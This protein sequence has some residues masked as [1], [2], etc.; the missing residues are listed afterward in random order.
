MKDELWLFTMQ[1]PFGNGEAFLEN[2]LP[3]LAEGFQRV[4]LFPM[5]GEGTARPLPPGVQVEKSFSTPEAYRPMAWWRVLGR[6][7]PLLGL[8]RQARS[9]APSP[10]VYRKHRREFLSQLRQALERERLF[11]DRFAK[12][13]RPEQVRLYSYWTGDWATVLGLWKRRDPQVRFVSRM[14]GF[15]MFDHRAP[16]G[17]QRFQRFHLEQVERVYVIAQA[18]MEHVQRRFPEHAHKLRLSY[19]ATTDHGQAP[20]QPA[21]EL[22][23]ASCANLVELKRVHLIA[24]ALRHV[25]GP[26]QWTHF[27]D[28]PERGRVEAAVAQLP[29]TVR[30]ELK[31]SRPNREVIA[32]YQANPVDVFV[33]ASRTEGGAPVALQEAASFGI[34]L[35]AADA[36]G[37]A[38]V[39]TPESGILLPNG[40]TAQQL[41]R[42]LEGFKGS[43]WYT[44]SG[45]AAVRSGWEAR[46]NAR[47]VHARLTEELKQ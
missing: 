30:V 36:G 46:F 7:G 35:V 28:G 22:R 45:R 11:T 5:L 9:S 23:I 41:G 20:W 4:R 40:L 27:G 12:A 29:S 14:M 21:V 31:G 24:E 37:V 1:F 39:V 13:Y 17:W 8:L 26:V 42:T 44:A 38:E 10:A 32:W 18:G 3:F 6:M 34:P 33:H 15:D 2:E 19:L 43:S 16:D 47:R 25:Q